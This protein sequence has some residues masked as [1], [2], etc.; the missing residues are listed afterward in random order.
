MSQNIGKKNWLIADGFLP[1]ESNGAFN[2]HE[3]V[4]ILN[5]GDTDAN[6]TLTIYFE[7]R[8]PMTGFVAFCAA[9]RTNHIRLDKIADS[10]GNM[11]P[12]GVPYAIK[13]ESSQPVLAQH[14]RMDTTQA[15]MAL[16]TTMGYPL[17]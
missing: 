9:R 8:E 17:D 13:V 2:S 3:S 12:L 7:D 4:C 1:V 14:T 5:M 10:E 6:I 15:E 16:M 11:I